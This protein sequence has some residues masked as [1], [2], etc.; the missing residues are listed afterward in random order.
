MI[1][2]SRRTFFPLRAHVPDAIRARQAWRRMALGHHSGGPNEPIG[3]DVLLDPIGCSR[4][5]PVA[6]GHFSHRTEGP[7]VLV[8]ISSTRT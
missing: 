4:R 7:R 6:W 1:Y 3:V 5:P 2:A 8:A